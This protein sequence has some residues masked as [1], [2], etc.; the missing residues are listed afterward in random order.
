MLHIEQNHGSRVVW[1]PKHWSIF[2]LVLKNEYKM[3][4]RLDKAY[5]TVCQPPKQLLLTK[6]VHWGCS[7]V[8][9][10]QRCSFRKTE[11]TT[12]RRL[13][14]GSGDHGRLSKIEEARTEPSR[15]R[16]ASALAF[17]RPADSASLP[18][19]PRRCFPRTFRGCGRIPPCLGTA[20]IGGH[21]PRSLPPFRTRAKVDVPSR[22][23]GPVARG[24]R[25]PPRRAPLSWT[26][27]P[28]RDP[29]PLRTLLVVMLT[30][31]SG[32]ARHAKSE[33]TTRSYH[34]IVTWWIPTAGASRDNTLARTGTICRGGGRGLWRG[35]GRFEFVLIPT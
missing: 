27:R 19:H 7:S 33:K 15:D 18:P 10:G 16:V 12:E 9:W 28:S 32:V 5:Y 30:T 29:R 26:A 22:G 1:V 14:S 21:T 31:S 3:V 4:Q 25:L 6:P 11:S 2:S 24:G 34:K 13:G 35:R 8:H 20:S 17:S 23:I